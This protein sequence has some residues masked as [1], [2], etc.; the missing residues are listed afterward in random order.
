MSTGTVGVSIDLAPA[1]ADRVRKLGTRIVGRLRLG[2]RFEATRYGLRRDLNVP[3]V[4]PKAKIPIAVRPLVAEDLPKLL[5]IGPE[6]SAQDR[7]EIAWRRAFAEKHL[8]GGHVAIDERDGSPCY[9][10]WLLGAVDNDFIRSLGGFPELARDEALL[11]NAYT[12]AGYRGLGIMPAAMSQIAEKAATFGARYVITF[13]EIGNIPSLKG[14]QRSGFSPHLVHNL[15]RY[16][17]GVFRRDRFIALADD[18][19]RRTPTY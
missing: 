11:E 8:A 3:F 14:C 10:Q 6:T 9:V 19:P 1:F 4:A 7:L 12:P 13:V 15:T 16:G 17:F 2:L 5:K 18:D